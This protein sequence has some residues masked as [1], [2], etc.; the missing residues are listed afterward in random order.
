MCEGRFGSRRDYKEQATQELCRGRR[1]GS[2]EKYGSV[3]DMKADDMFEMIERQAKR[4]ID[5]MAIHSALNMSIIDRL[6]NQ[7]RITDIVSRGGAFI[8]GWMLHNEQDNPLYAQFNR[9][10]EICKKYDVTL[11]IGDATVSYT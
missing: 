9:V 6:K 11:S 2:I 3:V 4:G 7:G 10:L 1:R 8:T 5:F